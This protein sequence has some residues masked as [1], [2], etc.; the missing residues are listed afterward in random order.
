MVSEKVRASQNFIS[1]GPARI[2]LH[3]LLNQL[4][5][6]AQTPEAFDQAIAMLRYFLLRERGPLI[7]N[8]IFKLF[9]CACPPVS[10]YTLFSKPRYLS[11][12]KIRDQTP[13]LGRSDRRLFDV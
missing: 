8:T 11:D 3:I 7:M 1:G 6:Q 12:K 4:V 9:G 5:Q 2:I 10:I 13:L